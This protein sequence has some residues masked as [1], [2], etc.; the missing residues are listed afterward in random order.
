MRSIRKQRG[1]WQYIIP[2]AASLISSYLGKQGQEDTN[3]ENIQ[4]G[5]EQI[6]FQERMSSTAYQRSTADM[7]AAGLNPM[8]AYQQ[9][10]ASSPSG[11][12]PQ[13]QNSMAAGLAS[14]KQ[15]SDTFSSVQQVAYSKAQTD[16]V[17]AQAEKVRSETMEQNLNTALLQAQIANVGQQTQTGSAQQNLAELQ[18]RTE[19]ERPAYVRAETLSTLERARL[20]QQEQIIKDLIIAAETGRDHSTGFSADVARRKAEATAAQLGLSEAKASSQFYE[21]AG[22]L[23]P[24]LKMIIDLIRGTSSAGSA[25]LKGFRK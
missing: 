7:Q 12:M 16:L 14:G 22:Q 5:R 13:I 19:Y 11:A 21:G 15:A 4:L 20:T 9:G 2:A 8:L 3:K 1:W 25:V 6:A 24:Y 10:G 18:G 23:N 17:Q